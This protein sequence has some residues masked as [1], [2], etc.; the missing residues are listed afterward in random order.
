M[1][2]MSLNKKAWKNE[3]FRA[4][5]IARP[6]KIKKIAK[7]TKNSYREA[8]KNEKIRAKLIR[9][10]IKAWKNEKKRKK[11]IRKPKIFLTKSLAWQF[12]FSSISS[13]KGFWLSQFWN[14]FKRRSISRR[15]SPKISADSWIRCCPADS[16]IRCCL[17]DSWIRCCPAD[18]WIRCCPAKAWI[19]CCPADS[20]IRCCP[21]CSWI[22]CCP[23]DSWIRCCSAKAWPN[24]CL[25]SCHGF[26][27]NDQWAVGQRPC[28]LQEFAIVNSLNPKFDSPAQHFANRWIWSN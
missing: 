26:S 12:S 19:R 13:H 24:F 2:R 3:K 7:L 21:A 18:S 6:E 9:K 4:K 1:I 22:R 17:A 28:P 14:S 8:W 15:N 20:W 16:W 5:P 23:A 25:E 10:P 11:L 27:T